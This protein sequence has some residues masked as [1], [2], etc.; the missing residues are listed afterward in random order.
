MM[1]LRHLVGTQMIAKG[2]DF[3]NVTLSGVVMA[4]IGLSLP[5]YR[6]AE[7][8]FELIAQAGRSGRSSK[9]GEAIIQ[10]F[11][12][13]HYA[14]VYGARQDYE[15]FFARE[16]QE[17]KIAHYPPMFILILA[18]IRRR[19]RENAFKP[20]MISKTNSI[21]RLRILEVVG[22]LLP[23]YSMANGKHKRIMLLKFKKPEVMPISNPSWANILRWVA[24][25]LQ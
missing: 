7:R 6:A 8:T 13:S 4:D 11:N 5:T 3:P 17:R 10:T 22:P 14:I 9:T 21:P 2:H 12:P 20:P 25:I 15:G 16:M 1:G 24:W 18:R 19:E 23:Y